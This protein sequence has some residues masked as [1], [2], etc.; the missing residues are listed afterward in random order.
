MNRNDPVYSFSSFQPSRQDTQ[1]FHKKNKKKKKFY[2]LLLLSSSLSNH[3]DLRTLVFFSLNNTKEIHFF[4][5]FFFLF[6][7]S[8]GVFEEIHPHPDNGYLSRFR[9]ID[10]IPPTSFPNG[11][12]FQTRYDRVKQRLINPRVFDIAPHLSPKFRELG[13]SRSEGNSSSSVSQISRNP[14][15]PSLLIFIKFIQPMIFSFFVEKFL[16]ISRCNASV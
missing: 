2:P 7:R 6:L 1:I 11:G 10:I 3:S 5:F 15:I 8:R 9:E 14:N 4:L 13:K 12:T 16:Q